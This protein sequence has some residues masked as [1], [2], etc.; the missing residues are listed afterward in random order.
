[1]DKTAK[2]RKRVQLT[3]ENKIKVC[4][5]EKKNVLKS[6]IMSQFSTGKSTLNEILRSEQFK[7]FKAEK[8]ELGLTGATKT[9]KRVEGGYFDKLD[10]SIYI[11]FRQEREKDCLETGAVL[12]EN[13]SEFHHLI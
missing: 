12:L 9:A 1:M 6:V 8:E 3:I 11:W 10:S 13:A 2:K 7:K 4:E 5:M